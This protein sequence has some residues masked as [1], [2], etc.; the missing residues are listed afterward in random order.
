MLARE[1]AEKLTSNRVDN[2]NKLSVALKERLTL[3]HKG[4]TPE[5]INEAFEKKPEVFRTVSSHYFN[6][7]GLTGSLSYSERRPDNI[8]A[9]TEKEANSILYLKNALE[10]AETDYK[11]IKLEIETALLSLRTY[12]KIQ[13]DFEEAAPFLTQKTCAALAVNLQE[14]KNKLKA[15]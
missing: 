13:E 1:I 10:D 12:K 3:I 4:H 2:I 7:Y 5:Y 8:P 6:A 11:K 15:E 9:I 14:L